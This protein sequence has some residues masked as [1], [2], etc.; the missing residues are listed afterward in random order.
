[1]R[2]TF[3]KKVLVDGNPCAKCRDVEE[4]LREN[5]QLELMD[6][7]VIADERDA[8]SAGMQLARKHEVSRAPFFLVEE[9]GQVPR[10]YTVYFK[11][12]KEVL[13]PLSP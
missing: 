3:V 5:N 1:M 7:I 13:R 10:V 11:F 4:K 6:Q 12:V 2:I 9:P 8:D